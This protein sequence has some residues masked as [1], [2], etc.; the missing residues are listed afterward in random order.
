VRQDNLFIMQSYLNSSPRR[1]YPMNEIDGTL[2]QTNKRTL[3]VTRLSNKIVCFKWQHT[4]GASI[5][6][7]TM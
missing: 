3:Q 2:Q 5:P 1:C 7:E 6:S 4:A